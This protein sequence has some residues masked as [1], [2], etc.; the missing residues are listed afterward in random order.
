MWPALWPALWASQS[1][2][3][4]SQDRTSAGRGG[5][6]GAHQPAAPP[7]TLPA[8]PLARLARP[9]ARKGQR[10]RTR[11]VDPSGVFYERDSK[12][13]AVEKYDARG[14]HLGEFDPVTGRQ[15]KPRNPK[16]QAIP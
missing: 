10:P 15:L 11:W 9:K 1:E 13:A 14:H 5:T 7:R 3:A 4:T 2:E 8:F 12:S 16:C 6:S